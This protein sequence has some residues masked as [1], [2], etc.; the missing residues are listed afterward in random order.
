MTV[1]DAKPGVII[2]GAGQA[3]GRTAQA[4]RAHGFV[5]PITLIGDEALAPYERPPLSKDIL[6]GQMQP[7]A[8]SLLADSEWRELGVDLRLKTRVVHIDRAQ[9][10]IE[11]SST[12]VMAYDALVLATGA[13]PRPFPGK[14]KN[15][16]RVHYLRTVDDALRLK[17]HLRLGGRL[18]VV[19]AGFIGLELA[20]GAR[21]LGAG[22]DVIELGPRPLA[23][24]LP[25]SF[26]G[27]FRRMHEDQ[28]VRFHFGQG[29]LVIDGERVQ[30]DDGRQ[31]TSDAIVVGIGALP[32]DD[33]AA[34]AGLA[35]GP[36]VLV[37]ELCRTSD[38]CIYA[39]GDVATRTD[40]A[41]GAPMRLES[42]RNAEDQAQIAAAALCS[43][44]LKP[45]D[46][47]WFWTD[48]YGRNIQIAGLPDDG[49]AVIKIGQ[50]DH[51]P[52]LNYFLQN[53]VLQ[54]VIGV[55]C[56]REVR[57]A[58]KI[59]TEGQP[60]ADVDLPRPRPKKTPSVAFP[61]ALPLV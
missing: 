11:L 48:Q 33:I 6:L 45:L 57:L 46:A 59:I 3:G 26:A 60:V 39:V 29:V 25:A 35:V 18:A 21:M 47:P 20:A 14:I 34:Q 5:G 55:D 32:N 2:V 41:G 10:C 28:G 52:Y 50:P 61:S 22:V 49:M 51:G 44:S 13:R 56:G 43:S 15:G 30:L 58:R 31:I 54:G 42:W 40:H 4:L 1:S 19:G 9:K 38:P 12:G 17:P 37:D 53:G 16:A 36:G 27:W 7:Q 8:L 24:L 23:R